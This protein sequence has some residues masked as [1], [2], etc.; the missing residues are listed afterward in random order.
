MP[1][2]IALRMAAYVRGESGTQRPPS[3]R[4]WGRRNSGM[5][6]SFQA[7]HMCTPFGAYR[8]AAA[9]AKSPASRGSRGRAPNG[10]A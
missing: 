3:R 1:A 9:S 10:V 8:R 5:L 7:S 6:G 2:Y 4:H